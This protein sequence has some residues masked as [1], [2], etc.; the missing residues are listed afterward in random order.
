MNRREFADRI[1]YC[2]RELEWLQAQPANCTTC[3]QFTAATQTCKRFGPV[4]AHFVQQGCEEWEFDET[5]F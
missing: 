5:P 4:P 1:D 2:R 3:T